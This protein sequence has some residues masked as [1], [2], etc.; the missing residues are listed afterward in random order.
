[1]GKAHGRVK[2]VVVAA[3]IGVSTL[4]FTPSQSAYAANQMPQRHYARSFPIKNVLARNHRSGH[5]LHSLRQQLK[6][7]SKS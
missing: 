3:A 5:R 6:K 4:A 1:M 7:V 2:R